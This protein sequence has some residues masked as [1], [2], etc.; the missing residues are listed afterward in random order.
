MS[1][2][3]VQAVDVVAEY[4]GHNYLV[5]LNDSG[6]QVSQLNG[7]VVGPDLV[8]KTSALTGT[9]KVISDYVLP[10][11]ANTPQATLVEGDALKVMSLWQAAV[12]CG[13]EINSLQLNYNP[14]DIFGKNSNAAFST[15]VACMKA[16][17]AVVTD[18]WFP[19]KN[20]II[21][22]QEIMDRIFQKAVDAISAGQ[23]VGGGGGDNS[24]NPSPG[25]GGSSWIAPTSPGSKTPGGYWQN[26]S[27]VTPD[28]DSVASGGYVALAH[29]DITI[30]GANIA[31]GNHFSI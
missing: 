5:L 20:D 29:Q 9:L 18:Q 17:E 2:K 7:Y 10:F 13:K 16:K 11:N 22:P 19:G 24:G 23:G 8:P 14:L 3:I 27:M 6:A 30:I 25:G 26:P 21:L 31:T 4:G 12:E 1:Y 28:S 15:L